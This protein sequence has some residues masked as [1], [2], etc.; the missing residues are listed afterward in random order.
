MRTKFMWW[1]ILAGVIVLGGVLWGP[2]VSNVEEPKYKVISTEQTVQ[3]REYPPMIVA[4]TDIVG[5][6]DKAIR[7]GFRIIADYIF[8]NNVAS[9]KIAM[10][11]PVTQQVGEKIAMTAPVNQQ[12]SGNAWQVRFIMPA[13]YTMDTLPKPKNSAVI[14]K[15]IE[16]KR[17]AVIRFSGMAGED[18]LKRQTGELKAY[19]RAKNLNFLSA[20]TYA[21]YNPPWTLPFLR[22]NEVMIEVA[23]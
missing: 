18:S 14:L 13:N 2:L 5:E 10:T 20:P 4:E 1:I 7:E 9:K 8:G 17:F 12:I 15:E 11:A 16:G 22:R 23:R 6:R 3:I 21:F 19:V